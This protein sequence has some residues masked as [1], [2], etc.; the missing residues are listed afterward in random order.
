M[1]E[2]LAL[3]EEGKSLVFVSNL[4]ARGC[5]RELVKAGLCR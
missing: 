5:D 1:R 4:M 2:I 3:T